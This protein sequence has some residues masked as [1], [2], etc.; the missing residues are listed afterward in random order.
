MSEPITQPLVLGKRLL[1]RL[2]M[3]G[4]TVLVSVLSTWTDANI[5][6]LKGLCVALILF[7]VINVGDVHQEARRGLIKRICILYSNRQI[8]KLFIVDNQNSIGIFSDLLLSVGL[9][10]ALILL[11]DR[12]SSSNTGMGEI[13]HILESLLYLYGNILDFT[14]KYGI[15]KITLCAFGVS[16]FVKSLEK[17]KSI[18]MQFCYRMISIISANLLYEGMNELIPSPPNLKILQT[19][20]TLTILRLILTDLQYYLTYL[21][22]QQLLIQFPDAGPLFFMATFFID[23]VPATSQEWVSETCFTYVVLAVIK[24]INTISLGGMIFILAMV[25]YAEYIL[26]ASQK[27]SV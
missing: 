23:F 26:V 14:F 15:L 13:G 6:P 8:R 20:A 22:A 17:P 2:L 4:G 25:H 12:G 10:A 19:I 24:Y 27:K 9:T 5:G 1:G 18:M 16:M 21:A 3:S 11:Y 7:S